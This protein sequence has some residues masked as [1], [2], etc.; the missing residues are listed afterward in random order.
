MFAKEVKKSEPD[1]K[2]DSPEEVT[3]KIDKLVAQHNW[4]PIKWSEDHTN[5]KEETGR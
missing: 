5:K 4:I 2:Q 3:E 1:E